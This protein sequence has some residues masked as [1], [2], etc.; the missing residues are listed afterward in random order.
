MKLLNITRTVQN[1][2]ADFS[3]DRC[4]RTVS[5]H[6]EKGKT[7]VVDIGVVKNYIKP[8]ADSTL[9]NMRKVDLIEYIRTLEH[10]YNVA[11]SFNENQAKYIE[12]LGF[13]GVVFCKDCD[14]RVFDDVCQEYFC[15]SAYGMCG[16]IDDNSFCS[17]GERKDK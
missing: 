6:A 17:Y 12:S 13:T 11:V 14:F 16:A 4:K 9:Y 2:F 8:K 10:N 7:M 15:N 3:E 5:A 1:K